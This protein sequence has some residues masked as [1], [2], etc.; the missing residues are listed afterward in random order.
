MTAYGGGGGGLLAWRVSTF[1]PDERAPGP[2]LIHGWLGPRCSLDVFAPAE[3]QRFLITI[4]QYRQTH[5]WY[6]GM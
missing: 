2:Y 1:V 4:S 3:T 6:W 5:L